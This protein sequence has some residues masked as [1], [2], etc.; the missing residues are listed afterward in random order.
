MAKRKAPKNSDQPELPLTNGSA[1]EAERQQPKGNR[2]QRQP[3]GAHKC[4]PQAYPPEDEADDRQ[5]RFPFHSL[6]VA[7]AARN[8]GNDSY[9]RVFLRQTEVPG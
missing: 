1:P 5:S 8:G 6:S 2:E 7:A 3:A 9:S 4:A